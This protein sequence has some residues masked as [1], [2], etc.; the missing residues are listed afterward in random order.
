MSDSQIVY[1]HRDLPPVDAELMAEH[2]LEATSGRVAESIGQR[3]GRVLSWA[4]APTELFTDLRKSDLAGE[5]CIAGFLR[6]FGR[7]G[8]L[9][10]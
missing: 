9:C 5:A 3:A 7:R 6:P 2:T 1:W 4:L 10:P 8:E